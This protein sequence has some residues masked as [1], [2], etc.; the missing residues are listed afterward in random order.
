MILWLNGPFGVGKTTT[1]QAICEGRSAWTLFDP[2]EIGQRVR[3]EN[4]EQPSTDF[5]DIRQWRVLVPQALCTHDD[6]NAGNV[7]APQT[8]LNQSYW[9]E[10]CHQFEQ[11]HSMVFHVMLDCDSAI[12]AARIAND[13][14]NNAACGWRSEHLDQ[15]SIARDWMTAAADLVVDTSSMT[16]TEVTTTILQA[17]PERFTQAD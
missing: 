7:V 5:Q 11:H 14:F 10:M 2:E 16:P 4:P 17:L 6:A 13:Q 1:A 9:N 15:Y 3:V 8:V 12:L